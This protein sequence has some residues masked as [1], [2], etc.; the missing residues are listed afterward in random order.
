MLL[1]RLQKNC[2][3]TTNK[4]TKRSMTTDAKKERPFR[5]LG[6][7][8]IALG[9]LE[10]STLMPFWNE[11]LGIPKVGN[12]VSQKENVDEDILK[13][14]DGPLAVEIDIMQP[15]DPNKSP[16][17]H[18]PVLNHVGL[19]IDDLPKAV[20][21]FNINWCAFLLQGVFVKV[22]LVMMFVLSIQRALMNS[23]LVRGVV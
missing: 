14:N 20:E 12:F 9:Q 22:H 23:Q 3:K 11:A 7:Q 19:W 17:V 16:K 18:I 1:K 4:K 15:L 8:Q 6:I 10:K 2:K 13:I 5:V 21:H